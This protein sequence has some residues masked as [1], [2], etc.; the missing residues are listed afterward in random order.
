MTSPKLAGATDHGRMYAR[1]RG[2]TL[3]VPSITTVL[4]VLN[5]HMEWWEARCAVDLAYEHAER[6][7]RVAAL[8]NGPEK[9]QQERA[10]KEWLRGAATRDRDESSERGDFVHDY[11]EVWALKSIGKATDADVEAHRSDCE[12]AGGADFLPHFHRFW[13]DF[14]PRVVIPEA[15][16]WN[17]T[18]GYAGTT[19]LLCE[20]EVQGVV[21]PVV[22]DWKTKKAL[23]KRNGQPKDQDLRD[24]TGMQLSA[25]A[26]GE[27]VW[28]P[29]EAED[30]S[31]D[32]WGPMTFK[33]EVGLAVAIAPDGYAVR[34]YAIQHPP[35]FRRF[36]ALRDAWEF[37]R[38]G[39]R[40]M[41][42]KLSGP[43][44]IRLP[45]RSVVGAVA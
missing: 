38:E 13:D 30:G 1:T 6:L 2:G 7:A 10:A 26:N 40:M 19:D 20:I 45:R 36:K 41:S 44:D 23:Y 17:H 9:W 31:Q 15:T 39:P 4:D 5:Q 25:A 16:V 3:E 21:T 34:Q 28:L 11:A 43:Q 32:A 18:V 14:N 29:G 42:E 12:R 22:V 35:M 27:E 37:Y 8:P 33:A 24:Y